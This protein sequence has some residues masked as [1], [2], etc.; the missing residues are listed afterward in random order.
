MLLGG[1]G[2]VTVHVMSSPM[3]Q[4]WGWMWLGGRGQEMGHIIHSTNPYPSKL[5]INSPDLQQFL[6]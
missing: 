4:V 1:R 5:I 6:R 3:S 2:D